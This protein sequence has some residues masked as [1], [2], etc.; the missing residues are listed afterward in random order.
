[1][2]AKC[3]RRWNH[4]PDA[5]HGHNSDRPKPITIMRKMSIATNR[6]NVIDEQQF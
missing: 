4:L 3:V 2:Q 5:S 1:M 6:L